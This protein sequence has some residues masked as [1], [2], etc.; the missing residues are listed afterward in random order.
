MLSGLE[1][2][3]HCYLSTGVEGAYFNNNFEVDKLLIVN[4]FHKKKLN[5][6]VNISET[7]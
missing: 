1:L 5:L 2:I 3:E 4:V 6:C 7:F